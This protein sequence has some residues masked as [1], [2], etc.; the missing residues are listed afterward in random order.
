[1]KNLFPVSIMISLLLAGCVSK[2]SSISKAI[3]L[4]RYASSTPIIS[5]GEIPTDAPIP[6]TPTPSGISV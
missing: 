5:A 3:A 2:G 1:M 6:A 4:T